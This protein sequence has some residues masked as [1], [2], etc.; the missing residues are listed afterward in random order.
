MICPHYKRKCQTPA[1]C[2]LEHPCDSLPPPKP[3]MAEI[4]LLVDA[5]GTCER[6]ERDSI[7]AALMAAIRAY[8]EGSDA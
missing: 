6:W 7:S 8:V 4:E 5:L 1:V 3:T 2:S